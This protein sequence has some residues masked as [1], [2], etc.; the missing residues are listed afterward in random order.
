MGGD[1]RYELV[2]GE[3]VPVSPPGGAAAT[4]RADAALDGEAVIPGFKFPL[5]ELFAEPD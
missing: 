2:R 5:N 3:L 1:A 4:L